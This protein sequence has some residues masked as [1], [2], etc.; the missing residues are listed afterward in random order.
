MPACAT[1]GCAARI[2]SARSSVPEECPVSSGTHAAS[3][4]SASAS[5]V[6]VTPASCRRDLDQLRRDSSADECPGERLVV[7]GEAGLPLGGGLGQLD[8]RHPV[9]QVASVDEHVDEAQA[10][11]VFRG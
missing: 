2:A 11:L 9:Q 1:S 5:P 6:S 10:R 4:K 8:L 3:M 7:T